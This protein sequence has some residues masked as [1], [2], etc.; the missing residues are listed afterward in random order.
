MGPG[1][2]VMMIWSVFGTGRFVPEEGL[3][4]DV[5]AVEATHVLSL[6]TPVAVGKLAELDPVGP[7]GELPLVKEYGAPDASAP[8]ARLL[9]AATLASEGSIQVT[10]VLAGTVPSHTF[11]EPMKDRVTI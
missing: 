10:T 11:R 8:L 2:A 9:F 7:V 4:D 6:E 1:P 3:L 5:V